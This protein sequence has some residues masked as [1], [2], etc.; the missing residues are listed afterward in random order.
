MGGL[1]RPGLSAAMAFYTVW[2]LYSGMEGTARPSCS[3]AAL[4]STKVDLCD[5]FRTFWKAPFTF[6]GIYC[7]VLLVLSLRY[8]FDLVSTHS[9]L[10][11]IQAYNIFGAAAPATARDGEKKVPTQLQQISFGVDLALFIFSTGC[12]KVK[13]LGS[14]GQLIPLVIGGRRFL[15]VPFKIIVKSVRGDYGELFLMEM[16]GIRRI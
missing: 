12:D 16:K 11:A 13:S 14:T 3:R 6:Y 7:S 1:I 9:I 8:I 5:W 10:E 15:K 2:F 4:S